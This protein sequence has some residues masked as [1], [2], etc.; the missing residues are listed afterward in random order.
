M[1]PDWGPH[2]SLKP[3]LNSPILFTISLH[4]RAQTATFAQALSPSNVALLVSVAAHVGLL[5][6]VI[7][8]AHSP[9][10]ADLHALRAV[11]IEARVDDI[12]LLEPA[13][14]EPQPAA[15]APPAAPPVPE[16]P[17]HGA[18]AAAV[19]VPNEA[20]PAVVAPSQA[21]VAESAA[22]SAPST[23][24]HFVM[25]AAVVSSV[26]GVSAPSAS[27]GPS[28]VA[29]V[30]QGEARDLPVLEQF[31]DAPATLLRGAP[32]SYTEAAESAGIEA[33]VPLEVVI[34]A[35]GSVQNAR[36]L[37]H[38]GYGLDEAALSAVRQY[39]FAPARRANKLV[40]VRMRW[41]MRFQ[42]R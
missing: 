3:L 4:R 21:K 38:V 2:S 1:L 20:Q 35:S 33:E 22:D 34:D 41:V 14:P 6:L 15:A 29:S 10:I 37:S 39:R 27:N 17:L 19:A 28:G 30:G 18:P 16:P 5:I 31:V 7:A 25:L 8:R 40:A 42:L 32:P 36:P 23:L 11:S 12:D 9:S 24:P 13:A 26:S